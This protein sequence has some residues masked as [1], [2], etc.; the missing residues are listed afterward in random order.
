MSPVR[1]PPPSRPSP[2]PQFSLSPA[3][4]DRSERDAPCCPHPQPAEPGAQAFLSPSRGVP[5]L[6]P[7]P[8]GSR[9]TR[10]EGFRF[11]LRGRWHRAR[12][13]PARALPL[14]CAAPGRGAPAWSGTGAGQEGDRSGTGAGH[15][16]KGPPPPPPAPFALLKVSA[17]PASLRDG[18]KAIALSGGKKI[19]F[20]E[21]KT[22]CRGG[23]SDSK[24]V[25]SI[26]SA[27]GNSAT[28][29][30]Y[31]CNP[32]RQISAFVCNSRDN[33]VLLGHCFEPG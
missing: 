2:Q 7:M 18:V 32:A 13:P 29:R 6:H 3:G 26:L 5:K 10:S 28:T 30:V 17:H 23:D 4:R 19:I 8:E 12:A 16:A 31:C 1:C 14:R 9:E 11:S 25:V 27:V 24:K 21:T 15:A 20:T 33:A 22:F